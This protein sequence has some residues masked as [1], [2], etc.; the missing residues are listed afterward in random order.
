M[1]I[2]WLISGL[3]STYNTVR[4]SG[5]TSYLLYAR[6]VNTENEIVYSLFSGHPTD[7]LLR[8]VD[9]QQIDNYDATLDALEAGKV[10]YIERGRMYEAIKN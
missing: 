4:F 9:G 6:K 7:S 5:A 8:S 10:T 3:E 2:T 1:P